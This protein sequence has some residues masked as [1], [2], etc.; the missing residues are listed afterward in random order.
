MRNHALHTIRLFRRNWMR[1]HWLANTLYA[2]AIALPPVLV[3]NAVTGWSWCTAIIVFLLSFIFVNAI[4]KPWVI[5]DKDVA[6]LLNKKYPQLEESAELLLNEAPPQS[7]LESLQL[8][9]TANALR[10]TRLPNVY[11]ALW[12]PLA[13]LMVSLSAAVLMGFAITHFFVNKKDFSTLRPALGNMVLAAG[14][15]EAGVKII[16]PSYTHRSSREQQSLH[17]ETEEGATVQWKL[18]LV[19]TASEVKF[20]FNDSLE[21]KL[22]KTGRANEWQTSQVIKHAGFYQLRIDTMVSELYRVE[23]KQDQPPVINITS[24]KPNTV[25]EYGEPEQV[26]VSAHVSDDYGVRDA[27]IQATVAKGSGEAVS[28]KT[29]T[30]SFGAS[31]AAQQTQYN[32]QKTVGLRSLGMEPGD[33]LYFYITATDTHG[34][35]KRSD[36]YIVTITDTAKLMSLD[37]LLNGVNIKPDYFR[38]QRQIILDAEQLL[39]EKDTAGLESFHNRSN[40]LGMDQKLLRLRY[41]KFLGE[42]STSNEDVSGDALEDPAHFGNGDAIL[43]AFTDKH[44]NAEDAGFLDPETKKQLKAVLTEM[45]SAE[46]QLRLFRPREALPFAYKALRLLKDL[47]QKSRAYVAKTSTKTPPIKMEKRLTGKLDKIVEPKS[48][49]SVKPVAEKMQE[50]RDALAVLEFCKSGLAVNERQLQTL[51]LAS[52]QLSERAAREP[53][54]YLS[55]LE[56]MRKVIATAQA[57]QRPQAS[58]VVRSQQALQKILSVPFVQPAK[59]HAPASSLQDAYF[60]NL[61]KNKGR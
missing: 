35:E 22:E 25:I 46:L 10:A 1:V 27:L 33:E 8:E 6:R 53:A 37:G 17:L 3:A 36:I 11:R 29:H 32:L 59:K 56:S 42:E 51:R 45:W 13:S 38:S 21:V 57:K 55:P 20:V 31:F 15:K 58:D 18:R 39:R 24:P 49:T 26:N 54:L 5:S 41:G 28:F 30:L 48:S 12:R 14:L 9:R 23:V 43:D 2:I 50:L 44:D 19:N 4:D 61:Q 34:Q 60:R 7:L 16:P 52:V 47:Q 40:N